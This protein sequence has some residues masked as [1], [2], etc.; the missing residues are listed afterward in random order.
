MDAFEFDGIGWIVDPVDN[1]VEWDL[2]IG[3][4]PTKAQ[5]GLAQLHW[6]V[7]LQPQH[8]VDDCDDDWYDV[9]DV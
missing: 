5:I 3:E 8:E 9:R 4:H 7:V 6:N 1:T 2:E